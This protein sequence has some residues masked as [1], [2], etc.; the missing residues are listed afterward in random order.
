[1]A[2]STNSC[3]D[4]YPSIDP[5]SFDLIVVGTGLPESI[6]AAAAASSGKSVLH[7]DPNPFYGS[8]FSSL[9]IAEFS[10]SFT[11]PPPD[12]SSDSLKPR[13]LYSHVE[14][15][16]Q[17]AVDEDSRSFALDLAGPRLL[18]CA[19]PMVDLL[20]KSRASNYVEFK[21]VDASFL[22]HG[23]QLW[24][25]PDSRQGVFTDETLKLT[26]RT[27][28]T[29][30]FKLVQEHFAWE[31]DGNAQKEGKRISE[32]DL[33]SPFVEFLQKQKLPPKIK[34]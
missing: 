11:R 4:L 10:S 8:H 30:F 31:G 12:S 15:S 26:E 3:S 28:L 24:L 17:D 23:G 7:L 20:I 32:E 16:K 6:I 33:E 22:F 25:V 34:E 19:D 2:E 21:S 27:R 5:F 18:F 13:P 1:M 9:S 29:M 14:F